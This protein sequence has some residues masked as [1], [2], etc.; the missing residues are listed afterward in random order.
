VLCSSW[1]EKLSRR[2][3][4]TLPLKGR[5]LGALEAARKAIH[6]TRRDRARVYKQHGQ[7][8]LL[9]FLDSTFPKT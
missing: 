9:V 1:G 8:T 3:T 4:V 6:F 2:G 7:A 5:T